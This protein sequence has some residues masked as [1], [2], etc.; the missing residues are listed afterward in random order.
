M[1]GTRPRLTSGRTSGQSRRL[2]R[3]WDHSVPKRGPSPD[4]WLIE[5]CREW[6]EPDAES[7]RLY[8]PAG[9][10]LKG[11]PEWAIYDGF[12]A[13]NGT[14]WAE[15]EGTIFTT[16]PKTMAGLVAKAK[17]AERDLDRDSNEELSDPNGP[18]ASIV[19]DIL[20]GVAA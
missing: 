12:I 14:R 13:R 9:D 20:A 8:Y 15:I 17:V 6:L 2:K 16:R 18:F 10:T 7:D 19:L 5:L 11:S 1:L 4:A 3:R